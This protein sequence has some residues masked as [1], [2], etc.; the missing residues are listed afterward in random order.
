M[1]CVITRS[2]RGVF[3]P[4]LPVKK[5]IDL[6]DKTVRQ[7]K[8]MALKL[9]IKRPSTTRKDDLLSEILAAQKIKKSVI[10]VVPK[11]RRNP[12][13]VSRAKTASDKGGAA[14]S[15]RPIAK[16]NTR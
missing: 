8:A 4:R 6:R 1:V 16:K 7:L 9:G 13:A 10:P 5:K 3:Q 14:E 15:A 2:P 12:K 11:R